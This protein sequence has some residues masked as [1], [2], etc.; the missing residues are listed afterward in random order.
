MKRTIIKKFKILEKQGFKKKVYYGNGDSE[1]YYTKNQLTIEVHHYL[2]TTMQYCL[3]VIVEYNEERSNIFNCAYF[4]EVE[5]SML[6]SQIDSLSG[7]D[8][9]QK[10][11]DVYASFIEKT[12]KR[13][14]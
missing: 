11:M 9:L 2:A 12:Y 13:F 10:A 14:V 5:I 8:S 4:D 3:E 6:K 1:I 7:P